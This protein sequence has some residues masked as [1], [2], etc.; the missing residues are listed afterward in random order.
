MKRRN[1]EVYTEML[2]VG[3]DV[4]QLL[5]IQKYEPPIPAELAGKVKGLFPSFL[6]K[7]DEERCLSADTIIITEEGE[8]TIKEIVDTKYNKKVLSHN[9]LTGEDEWQFINNHSVMNNNND[10]FEIE[11]YSGKTIKV[12]GNHRIWL[13]ELKCY[14]EVRDFVGEEIVKITV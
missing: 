4:S 3:K 13:P 5:G 9:V 7:T 1:G 10:W 2:E 8:K 12:T 14:R 11:L 6:R